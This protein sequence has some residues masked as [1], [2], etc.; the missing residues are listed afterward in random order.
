[1]N[2][3]QLLRIVELHDPATRVHLENVRD[4]CYRLGRAMGYKD[5]HA[6]AIAEAGLL[7]DVG[8]LHVPNFV[9]SKPAR[10]DPHEFTIV[11]YHPEQGAELAT[12]VNRKRLAMWIELHHER[13]DGTGYPRGLTAEFIPRE[14]QLLTVVDVFDALSAPRPYRAERTMKES[15]NELHSEVTVGRLN[16]EMVQAYLEIIGAPSAVPAYDLRATLVG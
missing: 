8:K 14:V 1:M 15:I 10:L 13:L 6:E 12:R 3:A 2:I 7:H 16:G 9:L 11:K 5:G 4:G